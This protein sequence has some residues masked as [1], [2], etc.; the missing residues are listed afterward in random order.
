MKQVLISCV[1]D[2][3]IHV[4]T[5]IFIAGAPIISFRNKLFNLLIVRKINGFGKLFDKN[6]WPY[7]SIQNFSLEIKK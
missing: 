5:Q 4:T 2:L 1:L 3:T 7:F 6:N